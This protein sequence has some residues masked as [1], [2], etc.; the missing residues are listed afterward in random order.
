MWKIATI[1][2]LVAVL[3]QLFKQI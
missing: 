3:G 2:A 1:L